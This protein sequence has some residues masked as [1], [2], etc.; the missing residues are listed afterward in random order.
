MILWQCHTLGSGVPPWGAGSHPQ[1]HSLPPL[2]QYL[3]SDSTCYL[4]HLQS[5]STCYP[6]HLISNQALLTIPNS[7][8]PV[9]LAISK[10]CYAQPM[11]SPTHPVPITC[12]ISYTQH[13]LS[14]IF[15]IALHS[16]MLHSLHHNYYFPLTYFYVNKESCRFNISYR[17]NWFH[18]D[19]IKQVDEKC[20]DLRI[21][22]HSEI[23]ALEVFLLYCF[24][25]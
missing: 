16:N 9:S 22:T 20:P 25:K 1:I 23:G 3:Q 15:T 12:G 24:H 6:Q 14:Q 13:I 8:Y 19:F 10:I 18:V 17:R 5:G 7:C 11:L 4:Q 2:P 21:L